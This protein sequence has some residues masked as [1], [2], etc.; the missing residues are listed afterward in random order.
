MLMYVLYINH[1]LIQGYCELIGENDKSVSFSMEEL[2]SLN[3]FESRLCFL[4]CCLSLVVRCRDIVDAY[5]Q[6]V[7]E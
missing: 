2:F 4:S 5:T 3:E 1:F 6:S 7:P